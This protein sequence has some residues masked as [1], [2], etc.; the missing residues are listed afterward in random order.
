MFWGIP[1][2][3]SDSVLPA[4][5]GGGGLSAGRATRRGARGEKVGFLDNAYA[6]ARTRKTLRFVATPSEANSD[7]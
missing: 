6:A 3:V 5:R 7:P 1:L 4:R 2:Q